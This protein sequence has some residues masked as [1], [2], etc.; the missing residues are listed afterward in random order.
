MKLQEILSISGA[1]GL[2]QYVA[3]GRGGIIVESLTTK[4]RSMVSGSTKVSALGDIAIF[5]QTDDVPLAEVFTAIAKLNDKKTVSLNNK[6]SNEEVLEFFV[7]VLPEF[8]Q[9]KVHVSDIKKIAT[10]YNTLI[11]FGVTEFKTEEQ[12]QESEDEN[13]ASE[14]KAPAAK[15]VPAAK[16]TATKAATP[17]ANSAKMKAP[18]SANIRKSQ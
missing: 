5:T 6:S 14:A 12:E 9:E 2:H 18:K 1:P 3:Q 15:K 7:K 17:K 16:K 11:E 4:K 8:D 13:N 10:W